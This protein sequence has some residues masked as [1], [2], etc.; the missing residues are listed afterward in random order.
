KALFKIFKNDFPFMV[1][2]Y[3][4]PYTWTAHQAGELLT[5]L[6]AYLENDAQ[7]VLFTRPYFLGSIALIKSEDA[8]DVAVVDGRRRLTE[9]AILLAALRRVLPSQFA[10]MLAVCKYEKGDLIAGMSERYR[11]K[12][13]E[14]DE[15]FFRY[16]IQDEKEP[17]SPEPFGSPLTENQRNVLDH[18]NFFIEALAHL[19]ELRCQRLLQY[20]MLRC[21]LVAV[22]A[23]DIESAY[24]TF[25]VLSA[26]MQDLRLI[27]LIR[28]E[29]IGSLPGD[30]QGVY[31]KF[32]EDEEEE[33][34]QELFAH[35]RQVY[36][37]TKLRDVAL[38][39]YRK[40]IPPQK[41]PQKFIDE[42]L[43]PYSEYLE[44]IRT[45]SY[46]SDE[47][48][49]TV[50]SMLAWLNQIDNFDWV[51]PAIL[52]LAQN[53]D[54]RS[55]RDR[56]FTDLERLAAGLMIL[57]ADAYSRLRRYERLLLAIEE[58]ADLEA[59]TSP[60]QLTAG[61]AGLIMKILAGD[62]FLAKRIRR[63][64]LLRLDSA[65]AGGRI[66]QED[67]VI[68]VEHVLPQ[69]PDKDSIWIKWFPTADE[70]SQRVHR[71]GNLV[72]LAGGKS[73]QARNFDFEKMKNYYFAAGR[74]ASP[75]MITA[76]VLQYREWTPAAIDERQKELVGKLKLLWRL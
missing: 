7:P 18:V 14:G 67:P 56:F 3:P 27:D 20:L 1:P 17:Q 75:F 60:L 40:H 23:P 4:G 35:V 47:G 38:L 45:A 36:R 8:P 74:G 24:H 76:Q 52:Y 49:P 50:N 37:K 53:R 42:V 15:E 68:S 10:A 58:R 57:R 72:L 5:D 70:R 54:A 69:N 44:I 25:S 43:R 9:F 63:Y 55:A 61:E 59:A 12:L 73:V 22:S 21:F 26:R 2:L 16:F 34:F 33:T 71:I 62:L 41:N 13:R 31:A 46:S 39:E 65:L 29:M 64:V 51:P 19:P 48:A 30:K 28:S 6:L 32:W 66:L 11:S